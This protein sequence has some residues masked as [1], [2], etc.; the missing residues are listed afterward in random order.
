MSTN[1]REFL[2]RS[3]LAGG[4]LAGAGLLGGSL[5]PGHALAGGLPPGSGNPEASTNGARRQAHPP[6]QL[7]VLLLGGTGFIGPHLV[8]AIVTRGHTLTLFNRG[9]SEP[10]LHQELFVDLENLIGDRNDDIS[11]LEGREWDVVIDNSGYTPDQVRPTAQLL[12]G[13]VSQYIFTSTRAVYAGYTH[14]VMDEDAP[15]GV[16]G[17]PEEEWTGYGPLK[18]LAER[19]V[20]E[21]FP[22][23][24]TILRPPIITGPGD[25]TDRFTYWYLRVARGGE[26]LAPGDPTDPLQYLDVRDLA[27]FVV[28][29]A[30]TRTTGIF[31]PEAPAAPLSSA[32]FLYGLRATT[33]EP[34]SFTWVDWDFLAERGLRGGQELPGWRA[35]RGEWLNYGR[36]DNR[37]A[38][39]AGLTF[40]P[41]AVTA[42]DTVAWW[43]DV[44]PG[45]TGSLRAGISLEREREA[46]E[47]WHRAGH[48]N[49][50]ARTPQA[51]AGRTGPRSDLAFRLG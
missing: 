10:G 22:D 51:P 31:N 36:I 16:P 47:A 26:V 32:E 39:A 5:W 14:P 28:H 19:D 37:R 41:L 1:R 35:P 6:R 43:R 18:A 49:L 7:R 33:G 27:E 24:T 45:D 3:I 11:A 46:L 44:N 8:H 38:L 25:G 13:S 15:V 23:G 29:L 9:R 30:E 17:V 4:G 50:E 48:G 20:Q 12:R 34:V 40:R 21:A 2:R 42:M